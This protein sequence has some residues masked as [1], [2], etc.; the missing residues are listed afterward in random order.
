MATADMWFDP[1]CPW[2][3]ITSR[4]LLEVER[5]RDVSVRFHVMSL[6]LLNEGYP[7]DQPPPPSTWGAVRVAAATQLLHGD[8]AVRRLYTALGTLIHRDKMRNSRDLYARALHQAG[9]PHSLANAAYT[10]FY[11]EAVIASHKAG[12]EPVGGDIG[13]P[14]IHIRQS[15]TDDKPFAF[16]GPVVSPCPRGE[17]AGRLWDAICQL[18]QTDGFYEIKRIRTGGPILTWPTVE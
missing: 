13:T 11:D 17:D 8:D 4:W 9:L 7:Q 3:W 15:G 16:F 10:S 12:L 6:R 2:A 1:A 5:V 18:F 14:I